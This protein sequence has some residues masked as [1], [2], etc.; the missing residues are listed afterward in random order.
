[1]ASFL[2]YV[3]VAAVSAALTDLAQKRDD[4]RLL[5][6]P[7]VILTLIVG[8]RGA[9]VGVDTSRYIW[10]FDRCMEVGV[11][12]IKRD[13]LYYYLS[14]ALMFVFRTAYA[15]LIAT[16]FATF[17]LMVYRLWDFRRCGNLGV[18]V[19][20]MVLYYMGYTMN[21]SRQL[22]AVAIVFYF[23]RYLEEKKIGKYMLGALL[24]SLMHLSAV[25]VVVLPVF[26]I[27]LKKQYDLTEKVYLA[28]S[29]VGA[30]AMAVLLAVV[31]SGY[32]QSSGTMEIGTMT[33]VR[34][35]LMIGTYA[36]W[37]FLA[38]KTTELPDNETAHLFNLMF[39][40]TLFGC[41][42]SFGNVV[43]DSAG[44]MGYFFR[45][46]ETVMFAMVL[47]RE[48]SDR[49]GRVLQVGILLVVSVLG[50][51]YLYSYNGIIPYQTVFF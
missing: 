7:V 32:L 17:F 46:F 34:L 33:V 30:L 20:I 14:V 37:R 50:F 9:E 38:T 26:Y 42:M 41:L 23:S 19:W 21:G 48:V 36:V 13:H 8:L 6:A 2:F 49:M 16:A 11:S 5:M 28:I 47:K 51:Y 15:P 29:A 10:V 43:V 1:M 27:G 31:Y 24:A 12:F 40:I 45:F 44:R 22:L 18:A 25:V 39:A 4:K 35:L 3:W